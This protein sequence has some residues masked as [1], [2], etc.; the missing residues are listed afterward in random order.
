MKCECNEQKAS[1]V[2]DDICTSTANAFVEVLSVKSDY[3]NQSSFYLIT[4][5]TNVP[6][7]TITISL[8]FTHNIIS[9]NFFLVAILSLGHPFHVIA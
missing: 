2:S 8:D 3:M 4:D 1:S 5:F 7:V 6:I 9:M